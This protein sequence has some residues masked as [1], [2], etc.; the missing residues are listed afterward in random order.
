[1]AGITQEKVG[2][3]TVSK[4]RMVNKAEKKDFGGYAGTFLGLREK[5]GEFEGKPQIRIELKMKDTDSDEV[6][7]IQFTKRA[8]AAAGLLSTIQKVDLSKPF[9]V[10]VWGSEENEKISFCG[11]CQEGYKYVEKRKTIEADKTFP[12]PKLIMINGEKQYDWTEVMV[13]M[14]GVIKAVNEKFQPAPAAASEATAAPASAADTLLV[15][16]ESDLPF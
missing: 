7:I 15:A 6:V 3:L 9:T 2:Y 4:G 14:D 11:I 13:A 16:D 1:M 5:Q 8:F 12:R 10:K